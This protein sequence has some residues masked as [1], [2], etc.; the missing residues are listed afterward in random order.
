MFFRDTF[1][2]NKRT[3]LCIGMINTKIRRVFT[4]LWE[5]RDRYTIEEIPGGFEI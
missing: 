2:F 1:V 3:K 4:K 5:E